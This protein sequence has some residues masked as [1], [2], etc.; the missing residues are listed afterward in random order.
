M[1]FTQ[2]KKPD[3]K[4]GSTEGAK[5]ANP[6][7]GIIGLVLVIGMGWYFFG[8]GLEQQAS[9]NMSDINN[10]VASDAVTQYSMTKRSGSKVDVCVQAGLVVAAYLQ[11]KDETNYKQWKSI[12]TADCAAAGV[13]M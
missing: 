5:K 1:N 13:P 11:A 7:G 2:A 3:E 6:V 10:K 9:S 4:G 8:G 12:Q